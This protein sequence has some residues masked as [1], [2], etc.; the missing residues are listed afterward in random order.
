MIWGGKLK[1]GTIQ[2]GNIVGKERGRR[3]AKADKQGKG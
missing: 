3:F 2:S 1:L